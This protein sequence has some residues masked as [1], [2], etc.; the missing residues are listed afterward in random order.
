MYGTPR[1][2]RCLEGCQPAGDLIHHVL[3]NVERFTAGRPPD[4]DRTLVVAR[5]M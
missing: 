4:D 3:D 5:V 1:L 2:D